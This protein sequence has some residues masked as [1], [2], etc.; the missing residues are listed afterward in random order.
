LSTRF[1]KIQAEF[2]LPIDRHW[3]CALHGYADFADIENLVQIEQTAIRKISIRKIGV[4]K[5]RVPRIGVRI[6]A[7]SSV[8]G[9]MHSLAHPTTAVQ[10]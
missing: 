5:V 10:R 6:S 3:C 8:G 2:Y 4:R 9:R 7:K 1:G